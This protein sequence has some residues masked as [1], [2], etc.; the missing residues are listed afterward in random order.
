MWFF[1]QKDN[2]IYNLAKFVALFT[3]QDYE[4]YDVKNLNVV[5]YNLA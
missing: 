3:K 4:L 5:C 2:S 1:I